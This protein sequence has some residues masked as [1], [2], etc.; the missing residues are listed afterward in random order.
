MREGPSGVETGGNNF[1]L[2]IQGKI[3]SW[4][5]ADDVTLNASSGGQNHLVQ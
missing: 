5:E 3:N 4:A 2:V 1:G